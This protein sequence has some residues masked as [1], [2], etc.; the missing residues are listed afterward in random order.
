MRYMMLIKH[1]GDYDVSMVPPS[2]FAA[3]GEF[4]EEH[5]K[6]GTFIDGAGLQPLSKATRVRLTGGKI[7]VSDGPFS[8]AKE[9]VGGY[10]LIEAKTHA[11][12]VALATRFMEI[13]RTHWPEFEGDSEV[14]PLEDMGEPVKP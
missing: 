1:P 7:V 5:I 13:H 10:S 12:A 3:M 6:N 11:D 8:E 9:V 4:V 2:L 14:R